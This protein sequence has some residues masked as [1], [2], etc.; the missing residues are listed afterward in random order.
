MRCVGENATQRIA[1]NFFAFLLVTAMLAIL[2]FACGITPDGIL[3][4]HWVDD[5]DHPTNWYDTVLHPDAQ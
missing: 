1:Q 5:G 3:N 2:A 4:G